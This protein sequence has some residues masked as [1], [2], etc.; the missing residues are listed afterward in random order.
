MNF[1]NELKED[2]YYYQTH[3]KIG[4]PLV[5]SEAL[6]RIKEQQNKQIQNK[7]KQKAYKKDSANHKKKIK[8]Y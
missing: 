7:T 3:M 4:Q 5:R 1:I 8:K 6:R 2:Y